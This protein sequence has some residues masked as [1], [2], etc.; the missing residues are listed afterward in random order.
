MNKLDLIWELENHNNELEKLCEKLEVLDKNIDISFLLNEIKE[1]GIEENNTRENIS[2]VLGWIRKGE[3]GLKELDF[4]IKEIDRSLYS[5]DINDLKELEYLNRE[6]ENNLEK[7]DSLETEIIK[8]MEMEEEFKLKLD[9]IGFFLGDGR[10]KLKLM[11]EERNEGK[12]KLQTEINKLQDLIEEASRK[13]PKE[14][15]NIYYNIRK[16]K[17]KGIVGVKAYICLGCNVRIPTYLVTN[18]KSKKQLVYCESCGRI[19][20]YLK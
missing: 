17:L 3:I 12:N 15:L 14:D 4:N 19:L 11:E 10:K 16:S 2:S 6:K 18:L 7:I 20:Y 13:I 5:G 1:K 9:E 8:Y